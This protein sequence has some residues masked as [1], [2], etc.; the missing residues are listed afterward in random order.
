M[1]EGLKI[2]I[3]TSNLGSRQA[4][5]IREGFIGAK[6]V[7]RVEICGFKRPIEPDPPFECDIWGVVSPRRYFGR[8][9]NYAIAVPRLRRLMKRCDIIYTWG[10][11]TGVTVLLAGLFLRT[12]AGFVYNIRDI[13]PLSEKNCKCGAF[14]R[15]WKGL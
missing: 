6:G 3:F 10:I 4:A 9:I 2:L 13:H 5:K 7:G 1:K 12:K 14:F 11:D 8:L 15:F